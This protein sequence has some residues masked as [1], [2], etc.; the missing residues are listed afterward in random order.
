MRRQHPRDDRRAHPVRRHRQGPPPRPPRP[1]RRR[2]RAAPAPRAPTP[3]A[4]PWAAPRAAGTTTARPGPRRTGETVVEPTENPAPTPQ[5]SAPT[6][7]VGQVGQREQGDAQPVAEPRRERAVGRH[8]PRR[9]EHQRHD[10]QHRPR[11]RRA[12]PA[13]ARRPAPRPAARPGC[14]RHSGGRPQERHIPVSAAV[15]ASS[16]APTIAAHGCAATS[17]ARGSSAL[18]STATAAC[19]PAIR[20]QHRAAVVP[21]PAAEPAQRPAGAQRDDRE[22]H[23]RRQQREHAER[24]ARRARAG[25]GA[26]PATAGWPPRRRRRRTAR[27][28]RSGRRPPRPARAARSW[29][30]RCPTPPRTGC[31]AGRRRR[32]LVPSWSAAGA[33]GT[34]D[35]VGAARLTPSSVAA[36]GASGGAG[37][38]TGH[39][40]PCHGRPGARRCDQRSS[41][42][43]GMARVRSLSPSSRLSDGLRRRM[44]AGRRGGRRD[45]GRRLAAGRGRRTDRRAG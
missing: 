6:G 4:R 45:L 40:R 9:P 43:R 28:P 44:A 17:A 35:P 3:A 36:G 42:I 5:L 7:G 11:P 10:Q 18:P 22:Q 23:R 13:R 25:S 39:R 16:P 32:R 26:R 33:S 20:G 19:A 14:A 38:P 2:A 15:P 34:G 8:H 30:A 37:T 21:E 12:R 31:A 27:R 1:A 24:L 29:P 41:V